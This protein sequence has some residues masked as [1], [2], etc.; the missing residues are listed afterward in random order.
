M[1]DSI[2]KTEDLG[3]TYKGFFWKKKKPSLVG[4]N[5]DI[6]RGEV[7]GFLGPNG[8]GK[9]TTIRLLM[10]LIKPTTGSALVM[11]APPSDTE[12]KKRIGFLPDS[13]AFSSYLSAYEFLKVCTKLFKIPRAE[14]RERIEEV[15]ETVKMSEHAGSKLGGFSRGMLQRI[16]I[17][18]AILNRPEL[19]ILDE[20]L[21][22]LD[23]HGRQELKDIILAQKA[24]GTSVFFCS[25]ILSDVETIC[26][27]VGI[28]AN[29][30]LLCQGVIAD[31]LSETGYTALIA[32]DIIGD[33]SDLLMEATSTNKLPS[34]ELELSFS[35][36]LD[37]LKRLEYLREQHEDKIKISSSKESL[38]DFFFRE[39][40]KQ[41]KKQK[42]G[43]Y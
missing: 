7:F 19:I 1:T 2:I 18:Q 24:K 9:T 23:P 42:E 21:V 14:Q 36:N 31:L 30:H 28:L 22:G 39:V 34:G 15:L 41:E 27:H 29:G 4:L 5:L 11:G 33:V 38:E 12:I 17:A 13:P 26:D 32:G 35:S 43:D 40:K 6:K 37:V 20:P 10:D 25:H 3:K 8:A 16:G